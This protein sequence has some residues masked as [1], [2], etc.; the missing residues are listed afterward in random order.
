MYALLSLRWIVFRGGIF[1]NP[2]TNV[3]VNGE[4]VAI[5]EFPSIADADK[6]T[7]TVSSSGTTITSDDGS[8]LPGAQVAAPFGVLC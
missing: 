5:Y 8:D 3:L 4:S 6:A 2:V 7:L 1:D